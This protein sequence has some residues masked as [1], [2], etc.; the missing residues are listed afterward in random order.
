MNIC[1]NLDML[2]Y[3]IA[4]HSNKKHV[5]LSNIIFSAFLYRI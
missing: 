4:A 5:F 3:L 1:L 2:I